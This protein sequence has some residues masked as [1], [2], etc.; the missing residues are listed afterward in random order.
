MQPPSRRATALPPEQRRA[1][2]IAAATPLLAEYGASVTTRQIASA[3]K[4]AEGTIFRVFPGKESL[5][6]A[7]LDA[8]FDPTPLLEKLASI[9]LSL[10]LEAR[11]LRAV[12][13]I[14]ERAE[15]IFQL[16]TAL[17]T[18]RPGTKPQAA[19]ARSRS[20]LA[21]LAAILEPDAAQLCLPP[22]T[23]AQVL[24]GLALSSIHP[25]FAV[26]GPLSAPEITA[27]ALHGLCGDSL[28]T[29][30]PSADTSSLLPETTC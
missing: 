2:I 13:F 29:H 28:A 21:A 15:S 6:E 18:P 3:A 24:R 8:V 23:A 7:V 25:F 1:A 17:N 26:N 5:I 12:E 11:I 30:S 10:P 19:I 4:I 9:D 20:E 22:L 16:L 27:L 14:T